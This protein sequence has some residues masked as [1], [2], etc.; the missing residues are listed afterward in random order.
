MPD[1]DLLPG[2]YALLGL[3]R[4]RPMHGYEMARA[5]EGSGLGE[6]C[7][8]EQSLLYSYLRNL[9]GRGLIDWKEQRVGKRP[10]RKQYSLTRSGGKKAREWLA[11]PVPKLR[12]VRYEFLVKLYVLHELDREAERDLVRAQVAVCD[13]YLQTVAARLSGAEENF[14]RLI[15][16]SKLSAAQGTANWLRLYLDELEEGRGGDA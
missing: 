2:E 14:E 15:A 16:S 7:P 5:F 4:I 10:P 8:V 3:L 12:Q 11:T 9:E 6:V 13:E 1:R